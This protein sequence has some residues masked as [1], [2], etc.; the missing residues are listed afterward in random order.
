MWVILIFYQK[1]LEYHLH[2][3]ED[4]KP[5]VLLYKSSNFA[6]IARRVLKHDYVVRGVGLGSYP[7]TDRRVNVPESEV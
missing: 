5:G 1:A 3:W 6:D 2:L 4:N 7:I